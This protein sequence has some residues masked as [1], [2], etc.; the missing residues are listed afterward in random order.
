MRPDEL[1]FQATVVGGREGGMLGMEGRR[2]LRQ[3]G[4]VW[5]MERT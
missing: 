1:L 3:R 5:G 2:V 4:G